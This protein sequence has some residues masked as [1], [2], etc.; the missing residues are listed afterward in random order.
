MIDTKK[1]SFMKATSW[2]LF[3]AIL[4]AYIAWFTTGDW[5]TVTYIT[6]IYHL[7]QVFMYYLHERV[8]GKITWGKSHGLFIQMTGLS[9]AGKSTLA[10]LVATRLHKQGYMVEVIDGDEYRE[11]LC[12][13]LGF[14]QQDRNT[15]IR[16]LGFVSKVLARNNVISIIA[17]INPYEN[18]RSEL[19]SCGPNVKTVYVKCDIETLIDRDTK[20]LYH[21]ALLPVSDSQH[22]PNF[23]GISD[24]FEVPVY[25]DLVIETNERSLQDSVDI[26]EK[27]IIQVDFMKNN[28]QT[29]EE[30]CRVNLQ[31]LREEA[32]SSWPSLPG[33]IAQLCVLTAGTHQNVPTLQPAPM[34]NLWFC[35]T[36]KTCSQYV[37]NVFKIPNTG[38]GV[39][40]AP[41]VDT[42]RIIYPGHVLF[43]RAKFVVPMERA[44]VFYGFHKDLYNRQPY[45]IEK[46]DDI[47]GHRFFKS[48]AYAR[49]MILILFLVQLDFSNLPLYET[50]T[51]IF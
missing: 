34:V 40:S 14:S 29:L 47:R 28:E 22:L 20:G 38:I 45:C 18:I 13:D 41:D 39:A 46:Y 11:G 35:G 51:S 36:P 48:P 2:R 27:S 24:P 49:S 33:G 26:L 15:N 42:P 12:N 1:R 44:N 7:V 17:A 25:P 16:R 10:R 6:V 37:C 23:T 9:G 21:R 30:Y 19:D 4:L 8:W 3:A 5:R 32:S 50:L 43:D 31:T